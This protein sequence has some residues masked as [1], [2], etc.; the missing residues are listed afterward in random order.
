MDEFSLIDLI[1]E[2][3]GERT[4]G[5]WVKVGPGDDGTVIAPTPGMDLVASIDCL[6]AEIHFPADAQAELLGYR[7]LMVSLSDLAAMGADPRYVLVGLSLPEIDGV[8]AGGLAAGMAEAAEVCDVVI[9]G[10]NIS[11]G[12]LNIT[13]SVHGEVPEGAAVTRDGAQVGDLVYVS[14]SLGGAAACVRKSEFA[15]GPVLSG[16][17]EAYFRP[18]ARF[19]LTEHLRGTASSAIDISDGLVQDAGHLARASGVCIALRS[20]DIEVAAGATLDDAMTGGDDYQILWT[21]N[22]EQPR[23][24]P[25]GV[26][27]EGR[28]V[29]VDGREVTGEAGYDHFRA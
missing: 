1:V 18:R 11:R 28:G 6:N 5:R 23:F 29:Y 26:V 7:A 22:S 9:A 8:W 21:S 2:R 10:G 17:Q 4:H 15:V 19:D 3:L 24:R 13:V 16:L 12:P 14:G 20:A 27:E 25:I